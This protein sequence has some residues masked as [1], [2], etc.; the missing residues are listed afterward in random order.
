MDKVWI[1][2][3]LMIGILFIGMPI[4][5]TVLEFQYREDIKTCEDTYSG[6]EVFECKAELGHSTENKM[7]HLEQER[8]CLLREA[9]NG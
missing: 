5:A 8:N 6:C 2:V 3:F 7:L 4:Y 9:N 1:V